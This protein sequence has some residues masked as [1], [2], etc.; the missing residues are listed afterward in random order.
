LKKLLE[1]YFFNKTFLGF[2]RKMRW[3]ANVLLVFSLFCFCFYAIAL[4]VDSSAIEVNCVKL[5]YYLSAIVTAMEFLSVLNKS[6]AIVVLGNHDVSLKTNFFWHES[7]ILCAIFLFSQVVKVFCMATIF[8]VVV[9]ITKSCQN[10]LRHFAAFR[11]AVE[12]QATLFII[13]FGAIVIGIIICV[14]IFVSVT[15][16]RNFDQMFDVENPQP[17]VNNEVE[18][19]EDKDS[20]RLQK[21]A[22]TKTDDVEMQCLVCRENEKTHACIPCGHMCLCA[23]CAEILSERATGRF[24]S[25]CPICRV[26]TDTFNKIYH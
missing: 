14:I 18:M 19:F 10:K 25:K 13:S 26:K 5:M 23:L 9:T 3:K 8:Y 1:A 15:I 21:L 22:V 20:S 11:R 2:K 7:R 12:I 17:A 16:Y 24:K 4:L 6:G